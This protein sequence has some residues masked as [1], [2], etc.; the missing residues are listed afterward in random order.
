M[1]KIESNHSQGKAEPPDYITVG[2]SDGLLILKTDC[3]TQVWFWLR[4][5]EERWSVRFRLSGRAV[6][7]RLISVSYATVDWDLQTPW[8]H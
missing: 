3:S 6:E 5:S 1:G 4:F 7:Y 2:G 8:K